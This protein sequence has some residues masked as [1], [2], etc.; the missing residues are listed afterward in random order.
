M[1]PP[2]QLL[3]VV[4]AGILVGVATIVIER[5]GQ[6]WSFRGWMGVLR[7]GPYGPLNF[8]RHFGFLELASLHVIGV[9]QLLTLTRTILRAL[10]LVVTLART[11]MSALHVFTP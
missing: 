9:V 10:T 11:T 5:A 4:S 3:R 1:N 7:Q 8:W 2:V 6:G